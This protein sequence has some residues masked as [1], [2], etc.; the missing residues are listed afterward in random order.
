MLRRSIIF[1]SAG[2]T[3]VTTL[4]ALA[5]APPKV[6]RVGVLWAGGPP[7]WR[8]VQLPAALRALGYQEP[9]NIVFEYRVANGRIELAAALAA[10]HVVLGFA[11]GES[12]TDCRI[13]SAKA[14]AR[15][16]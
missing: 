8:M 15:D 5:Q 11:G 2:V 16:R 3:L 4:P 12:G 14:V 10:D 9:S 7:Q 13:C 1:I 6:Y